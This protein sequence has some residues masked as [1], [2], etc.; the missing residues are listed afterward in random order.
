MNKHRTT[1]WMSLA[2]VAF[3]ALV[4]GA[5][6]AAKGLI[7]IAEND[8]TGNHVNI[9]L[10]KII[11]EEE[12]DYEVELVFASFTATWPAIAA[13][14]M[15]VAMDFPLSYS[16]DAI[17]KFV[18]EKK[19][20]E[21]V[22]P[23][24]VAN[25]A[26]LYVPTYLIEGDPE[27]GIEP[28]GADL[29]SYQNL[30]KY[31]SAFARPESGDMGFLLDNV[32]EW[33]NQTEER[34]AAFGWEFK[35]FYSGS[36]AASIAELKSAYSKGEPILFHLW[37]PHWIHAEYD[38]SAL[39]LPPYSDECYGLVEGMEATFSCQWPTDPGNTIVRTGFGDE[40]PDAYQFFKKFALT[41]AQY[42][43]MQG[44]VELNDK[45]VEEAVRDWM[46]G[47]ESVW[48]AWLP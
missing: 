45:T 47:N 26:R 13:G 36:D 19:Q 37:E 22:G 16:I 10:S 1:K 8:W 43:H 44:A 14:D 23:N 29:A 9:W 15:H 27:R 46:A 12:L 34:I 30:N 21:L 20:V 39:D 41:N 24:G 48:R 40:F 3:F 42:A 18:T 6:H 38:L 32:P 2:F 11:L 31:K 25:Q 33:N 17:A 28:L 35:T 5:A 7:K 4:G